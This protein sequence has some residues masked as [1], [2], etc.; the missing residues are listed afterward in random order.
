MPSAAVSTMTGAVR[1]PV[2]PSIAV[3]IVAASVRQPVIPRAPVST[4]TSP[5]RQPVMA[6]SG[7]STLVCA[8][9]V[10]GMTHVAH[11]K[12]KKIGTPRPALG[13]GGV[14]PCIWPSATAAAWA[15]R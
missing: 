3:S 9:V 14:T 1:Q 4:V 10:A 8:M 13:L 7:V 11:S 15:E 6:S 5:V 12:A 2:M